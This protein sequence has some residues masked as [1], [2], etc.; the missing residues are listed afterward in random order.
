MKDD[1]VV[2][3]LHLPKNGGNTIHYILKR[4]YPKKKVF[5]IK[6]K[7]G[8]LGT[9]QFI[10]LP[11]KKKNQIKVLKGHMYYGLHKYFET[12]VEYFTLLRNPTD[13]II[14]YYN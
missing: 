6:V 10:S 3:F 14:S 4:L 13:R 2:I 7:K 5:T 11:R 9:D 1:R 12:E 8:R